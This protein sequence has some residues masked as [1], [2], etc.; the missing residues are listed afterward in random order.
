MNFLEQIDEQVEE[1]KRQIEFRQYI[2]CEAREYTVPH[3]FES[4]PQVEVQKTDLE[5]LTPPIRVDVRP[6]VMQ[7][8]E[9]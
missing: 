3:N 4:I 7:D 6:V 2:A 5:E 9:I 8:P 1:V